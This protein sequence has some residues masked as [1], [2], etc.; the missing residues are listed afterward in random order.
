M[1]KEKICACCHG[2]YSYCP[3]CKDDE[4]K[5]TWM[6]TFCSQNCH[7]IYEVASKYAAKE[8]S[9]NKAKNTLDKLDLSKFE[10][11]GESYKKIINEINKNI[12]PEVKPVKAKVV[13]DG[14]EIK[15]EKVKIL[16]KSKLV[17]VDVE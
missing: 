14:S 6:F 11:F 12:K 4:D 1:S 13:T 16:P 10:N 17:K 15:E 8:L 3:V 2:N 9:A 7:D 5:P